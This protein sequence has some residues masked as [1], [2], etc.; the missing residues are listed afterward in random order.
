MTSSKLP[1]GTKPNTHPPS[2][3]P[4]LGTMSGNPANTTLN[5]LLADMQCVLP[6]PTYTIYWQ[7]IELYKRGLLARGLLEAGLTEKYGILSTQGRH[8]THAHIVNDETSTWTPPWTKADYVRLVEAIRVVFEP[9]ADG[10]V[11]LKHMLDAH[12]VLIGAV[13]EERRNRGL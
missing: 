5:K 13:R 3:H 11:G 8:D 10:D 2:I 12:E 6:S 7:H 1:S 4:T 9:Y